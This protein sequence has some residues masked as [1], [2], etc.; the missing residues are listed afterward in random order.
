MAP[1][2]LVYGQEVVLLVEVNL[3]AL[4]VARQNDLSAVDYNELMMDMID[5]ISEERLRALRLRRRN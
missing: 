3:Q 1:Y 5:E 2:D 4:R